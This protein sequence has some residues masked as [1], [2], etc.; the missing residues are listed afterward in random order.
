MGSCTPRALP[1]RLAAHEAR[2]RHLA[3]FIGQAHG[4]RNDDES[5]NLFFRRGLGAKCDKGHAPSPWAHTCA[6]G[7]THR[8]TMGAGKQAR[9]SS[10]SG[11]GRPRGSSPK[12]GMFLSSRVSRKGCS[13]D[14]ASPSRGRI[15]WVSQTG[16]APHTTTGTPGRFFTQAL[17][18]RGARKWGHG[19][20]ARREGASGPGQEG[21]GGG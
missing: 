19:S 3:A 16:D 15:P 1:A 2:P 8:V 10:A 18:S 17:V 5:C 9:A 21:E 11:R 12:V 20:G 4:R 14:L 7:V 13:V 6:P